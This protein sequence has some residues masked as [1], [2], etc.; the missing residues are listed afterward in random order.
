MSPKTKQSEQTPAPT[1]PWTDCFQASPVHTQGEYSSPPSEAEQQTPTA[2]AL[3][4]IYDLT[5]R[6]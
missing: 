6:S 3:N 4:Q 1:S 5:H 2:F